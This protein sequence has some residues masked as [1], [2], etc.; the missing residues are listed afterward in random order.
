MIKAY[1]ANYYRHMSDLTVDLCNNKIEYHKTHAEPWK[2]TLLDTGLETMTG[3][4]IK[5]AQE[6]IGN[7]PFMLTYGDGVADINI[8]E[9]LKFHKLQGG[10]ITLTAV[11]P[12]GKFGALNVDPDSK[13]N[14]FQEKP[15]GDGS[16]VNGGF[17]VCEPEVMNYID[18]RDDVAFESEPLNNLAKAGKL[19]AYKHDGFWKPMDMLRDKIQLEELIETHKAPWIKW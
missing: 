14:S 2:V 13:V 15:K 8:D 10:Y 11:L 1:F 6:Y 19:S 3:G 7:E 12:E 4:R 5:R 17:F 16:W 18:D 9:L